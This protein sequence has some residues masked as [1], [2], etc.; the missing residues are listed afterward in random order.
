MA[1]R[2]DEETNSLRSEASIVLFGLE[3]AKFD[4]TNAGT[5]VGLFL[6]I[7]VFFVFF[8]S[9]IFQVLNIIKIIFPFL[10]LACFLS[11]NFSTWI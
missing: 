1:Y 2:L 10:F 6:H 7:Y 11:H 9:L 3:Q 5:V 8:L 4:Y